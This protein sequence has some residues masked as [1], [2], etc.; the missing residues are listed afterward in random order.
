MGTVAS[1]S[2]FLAALR[3]IS[4]QRARC[5]VWSRTERR[6]GRRAC[7][8][9]VAGG[10][11]SGAAIRASHRMSIT[12]PNWK[13]EHLLDKIRFPSDRILRWSLLTIAGIGLGVG[14]L[15]HVVRQ[16]GLAHLAWTIATIPVALVLA[17]SIV[18]DFLLGRLGVDAVALLS[19]TASLLLGES[20]AGAVVALMYSGGNVLE[21][22]A[23]FRA[24]H[25]LR[26]LVDRAP[27]VAHRHL[28]GS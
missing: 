5:A 1:A 26:S 10:R 11:R 13:S 27:R 14:A 4:L 21:D 19:M 3:E 12:T 6:P 23:V 16:P 18:R 15:A 8:I 2:G 24:E 25:D 9:S 17:I 22:Y 28:H 7:T 20:L